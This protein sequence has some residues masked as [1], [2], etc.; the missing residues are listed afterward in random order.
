MSNIKA[1]RIRKNN[2]IIKHKVYIICSVFL[3]AVSAIILA[4][5]I[6]WSVTFS[7]QRDF[8]I[9]G[10]KVIGTVTGYTRTGGY[11]RSSKRCVYRVE[12]IVEYQSEDG[13]E[14]KLFEYVDKYKY[15]K[16][17]NVWVI[18]Q[19]IGKQMPMIIDGKGKC[20]TASRNVSDYDSSIA[21][22]IAGAVISGVLLI[23][24]LAWLGISIKR[25]VTITRNT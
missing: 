25:I 4:L 13:T 21:W 16:D 9:H 22:C 24:N 15:T 7:E 11:R 12:L 20:L 2:K 14:Y 8:Y 6:G 18:E 1:N 17:E 23:V 10:E 19:E 5:T 3:F